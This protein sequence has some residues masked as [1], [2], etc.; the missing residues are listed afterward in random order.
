M[1]PVFLSAAISLSIVVSGAGIPITGWCQ[2]FDGTRFVYVLVED[3]GPEAKSCGLSESSIKA[4]V[5]NSLRQNK[6]TITESPALAP[7]I[8]VN[9]NGFSAR[10]E[11]D[12]V[13]GC[14]IN[15]SASVIYDATWSA[16]N[17][18]ITRGSLKICEKESLNT[19]KTFDVNSRVRETLL[20][21]MDDLI[22]CWARYPNKS[23]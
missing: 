2:A 19:V 14:V 5:S 6:F 17:D 4:I 21:L 20:G 10:N 3:L 8:Y 15:T 13:I 9:V 12:D 16:N 18:K 22:D 23:G 1:R 11:A 7:I